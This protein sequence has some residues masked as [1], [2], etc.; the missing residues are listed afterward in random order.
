MPTKNAA[1]RTRNERTTRKQPTTPI[2]MKPRAHVTTEVRLGQSRYGNQR[3]EIAIRVETDPSGGRE[4]VA[5]LYEH[6]ARV[7]RALEEQPW[8]VQ[9]E[10]QGDTCGCVFLELMGEGP[11]EIQDA[12][13]V[14][15]SVMAPLRRG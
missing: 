11:E 2:E 12:M 14:L 6:A 1:P 15:A 8:A 13:E 7:A 3:P 10:L 5:Q 4:I 9:T